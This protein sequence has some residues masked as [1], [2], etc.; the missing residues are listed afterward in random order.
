MVTTNLVAIAGGTCAGKTT[1]AGI[2]SECLTGGVSVLSQDNYYP[3]R[4]GWSNREMAQFNWDSLESFDVARIKAALHD[5]MSSRPVSV[6]HYDKVTH[7]VDRERTKII[8]PASVLIFEG[9][10]AIEL[11]M[12]SLD[13]FRA[14]TIILTA[15]FIDCEARERR[16]RRTEQELLNKAVPGDFAKYW[17]ERCEPTFLA[18]ISPQRSLANLVI[19]SPW[20]NDA[21]TDLLARLTCPSN[22]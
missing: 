21:I 9:L 14:H 19:N 13:N 2:L 5:L 6:P 12:R 22:T 16:R 3:D 15:V 18:Q 7:A 8:V 1:L 10:H 11:A 17:Q 20:S 4:S